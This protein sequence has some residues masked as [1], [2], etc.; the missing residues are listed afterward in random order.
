MLLELLLVIG[1][2]A[3][4]IPVIS[5]VVVSSLNT[6][7]FTME[8]KIAVEL[9]D[10]A[11]KA[12][13]NV[14]FEKWQYIYDEVESSSTKRYP[15]KSNSKWSVTTNPA[16]GNL[17]VNDIEYTRYFT[18]SH[19][20]RDNISKM[21]IT[22]AGSCGD[23]ISFDDPSTQKITA[24]VSWHNNNNN[25]SKDYYLTRWR[26]KV[27]E[28]TEWSGNDGAAVCSSTPLCTLYNQAGTTNIDTGIT[29]KLLPN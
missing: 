17:V 22:T 8:N 19:V 25:V 26:N 14:S 10:E 29:L 27:Y 24:T 21:I 13:E 11:I 6:N 9:V 18:V 4:V 23:S 1:V 7:K 2:V 28:Q 15:N 3:I 12:V 16:D 5:Q 20:C